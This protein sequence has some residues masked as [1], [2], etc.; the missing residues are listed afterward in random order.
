MNT[1]RTRS[2]SG[3]P[4]LARLQQLLYAWASPLHAAG[5]WLL[6]PQY[7]GDIPNGQAPRPA[8]ALHVFRALH[9]LILSFMKFVF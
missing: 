4:P 5:A 7:P 9:S 2:L 8:T 1:E 6:Y 3:G